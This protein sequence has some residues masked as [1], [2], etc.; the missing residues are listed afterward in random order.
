MSESEGAEM[1]FVS[2]ELLLLLILIFDICV[3]IF[4]F[5]WAYF[6]KEMLIHITGTFISLVLT[7][8]EL[9]IISEH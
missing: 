1:A 6:E 2:I 4:A 5:L 8:V 3:S 9:M 7:S